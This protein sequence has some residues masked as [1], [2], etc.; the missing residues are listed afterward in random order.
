MSVHHRS[1]SSNL[2]PEIIWVNWFVNRQKCHYLQQG[3]I[4]VSWT[5]KRPKIF[6]EFHKQ[7]VPKIWEGNQVEKFQIEFL[8]KTD[9]WTKRKSKM[10][11]VQDKKTVRLSIQKQIRG[12]NRLVMKVIIR[13]SL[14]RQVIHSCDKKQHK[15][16]ACK[17]HMTRTHLLNRN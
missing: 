12:S 17:M 15:G 14:T 8:V 7:I 1:R 6:C 11:L 10:R 5:G 16:Q 3:T 4:I 2:L 13:A 9:L